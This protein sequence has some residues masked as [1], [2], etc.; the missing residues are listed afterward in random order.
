MALSK[1]RGKIRHKIPYFILGN[2]L[3]IFGQFVRGCPLIYGLLRKK[4][5]MEIR[6]GN[7]RGTGSTICIARLPQSSR[8]ILIVI[9]KL[10]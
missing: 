7:F 9:L 8:H 5:Y 1:L 6:Q 4:F 3:R 2:Y 10:A